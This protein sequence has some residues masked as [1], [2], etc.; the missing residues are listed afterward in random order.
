MDI[1]AFI[2]RDDAEKTTFAVCARRYAAEVLPGKRSKIQDG[3]LL[4]RLTEKFGQF[5]MAAISSSMLASYRD[6]RLTHVSPQTVVHELGMIS[7]VFKAASM[8]WGMALPQGIP[9][10]TVRKPKLANERSR[11]LE[12]HEE[13]LLLQALQG[14][15][16]PWPHAAAVLAIE[17][18]AR[19]SEL[20]SLMWSDV[21]LQRRTARLRGKDGGITKGGDAYRDVPLTTRATDLLRSL[22]RDVKGKV[23]PLSQNALRL[24][25]D[26]ALSRARKSYINTQ[27]EAELAKAGVNEA[28]RADDL[29][30]IVFKKRPPSILATSLLQKMEAED[31]T[32]LDLHFH[33]LRH[34][35]TTRLADKLQMHELMKVTGHKGSK[36]LARYYHPRAED[37]AAKLAKLS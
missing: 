29:R 21:D 5:S 19:Q 37:L 12:S 24:S 36:M 13:E 25:W 4:N 14:C 26:R 23:L 17:T 8:D 20:I 32:L 30:A 28:Q 2:Q 9:T 16:S 6:D 22:P 15:S 33:D 31:K 7:R 11:R 35:A 18:A 10:S 3:H 27:L 34:E 1:G